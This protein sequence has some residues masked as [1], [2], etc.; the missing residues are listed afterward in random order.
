MAG[1]QNVCTNLVEEIGSDQWR[2]FS[3]FCL[4]YA[5]EDRDRSFTND[6]YCFYYPNTFH[7]TC[8]R[9]KYPCWFFLNFFVRVH[10]FL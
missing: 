1:E 8:T 3:N 9:Y 7:P 2:K 10:Y 5:E 6:D 4:N